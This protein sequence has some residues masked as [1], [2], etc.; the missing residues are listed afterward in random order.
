M[1]TKT[2]GER[3][4]TRKCPDL[5]WSTGIY[6]WP[7]LRR[8]LRHDLVLEPE[9]PVESRF[10][11]RRR[12]KQ[13]VDQSPNTYRKWCYFDKQTMVMAT[14]SLETSKPIKPIAR[15]VMQ[16]YD[17][18][19]GKLLWEK[20]ASVTQ[21][22]PVDATKIAIATAQALSVID[23]RTGKDLWPTDKFSLRRANPSVSFGIKTAISVIWPPPT[24]F[25]ESILAKGAVVW[26]IPAAIHSEM[27]LHPAGLLHCRVTF[28]R[29]GEPAST[30]VNLVRRNTETGAIESD[31]EIMKYVGSHEDV[32][33]C[34]K[35]VDQRLLTIGLKLRDRRN[36]GLP[37]T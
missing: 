15:N 21:L 16:S 4:W 28:S 13:L 12:E 11:K 30:R 23:T 3:L 33:A 8:Q 19:S 2:T 9:N 25:T 35:I 22:G 1:S 14:E 7:A 24:S 10:G 29:R 34:L 6:L 5:I 18:A 31:I 27:T 36:E 37:P 26:H 17:L 32:R 20:G